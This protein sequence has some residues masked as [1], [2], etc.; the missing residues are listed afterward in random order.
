MPRFPVPLELGA[1]VARSW[2]RLDG[3]GRKSGEVPQLDIHRAAGGVDPPDQFAL[4][5]LV[6]WPQSCLFE[7]HEGVRVVWVEYEAQ[8]DATRA[9]ACDDAVDR[10]E[11]GSRSSTGLEDALGATYIR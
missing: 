4:P 6:R 11:G 5:I 2:H 7:E 8:R 9:R 10:I 1:G 3:V